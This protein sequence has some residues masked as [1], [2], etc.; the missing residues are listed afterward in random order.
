MHL[1]TKFG[2]VVNEPVRVV[3]LA[4]NRFVLMRMPEAQLLHN[5]KF[6]GAE[7]VRAP[8]QRLL[9]LFEVCSLA[10]DQSGPRLDAGHAI[11]NKSR[12]T[13]SARDCRDLC[14][15]RTAA[16]IK[17]RRTRQRCVA[18]GDQVFDGSQESVVNLS[19][20]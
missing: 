1:A 3:S 10:A 18:L 17:R 6:F 16:I 19:A 13:Q 9:D 15:Q 2:V 4:F 8:L 7:A 5:S 12:V 14:A 20:C 11:C